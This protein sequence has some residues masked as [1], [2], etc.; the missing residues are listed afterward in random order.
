MTSAAPAGWTPVAL[1]VDDGIVSIDWG[2]LTGVD[3]DEPFFDWTIQRWA[4]SSTPEALHRTGLEGLLAEDTANWPQPSAVIFHMSRCGSTLL[5]R[6]LACIPG[7]QCVSEPGPVNSLLIDGQASLDR[8]T[9]VS[10]LGAVVK[11]LGRPRGTRQT[12]FILKTSSWNIRY[13]S[14]FRD[15]FPHVPMLWLQRKPAD[16]LASM[17]R[18]PALWMR[19]RHIPHVLQAMFGIPYQQVAGMDDSEFCARA[20]AALLGSALDA[21]EA[22]V[23]PLEYGDLPEAAW[24]VAAPLLGFKLDQQII[25][26]MREVARYDAKA[27]VPQLF[28]AVPTGLSLPEQSL[29][30]KFLDPLYAKLNSL[31]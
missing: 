22:G 10:V 24:R 29:V 9:R 27:R 3:F 4:S 15:A 21:L 14:L 30:R 17:R 1:S 31:K 7:M 2:N 8:A 26:R 19:L 5:S 12:F 23:M 6:L 18:N 11:H 28:S 25:D 20:L 16:V 13:Y